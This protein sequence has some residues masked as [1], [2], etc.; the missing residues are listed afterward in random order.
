MQS[1]ANW[2]EQ[3]HRET[4]ARLRGLAVQRFQNERCDH[5]LQPTALVHETY[6]RMFA[7][8]TRGRKCAFK[9]KE[10]FYRAALR[11]MKEVLC[12]HARARA[13]AKRGGGWRKMSVDDID[14]ASSHPADVLI[15]LADLL[16]ALGREYPI[17]ARALQFT[18]FLGRTVDEIADILD[19]CPRTVDNELAAGRAWIRRALLGDQPRIITKKSA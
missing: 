7:G 6:L 12:D 2:F 1:D 19:V 9:D 18:V 8:S 16:H 5:T 3:L 10:A 15:D 13:T 14:L 11:V 4:Y 17:A